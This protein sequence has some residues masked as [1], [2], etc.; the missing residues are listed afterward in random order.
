MPEGASVAQCSDLRDQAEL[1]AGGAVRRTTRH[2]AAGNDGAS[3]DFAAGSSAPSSTSSFEPQSTL[4]SEKER[5]LDPREDEG[6]DDSVSD[7]SYA[8]D[9]PVFGTHTGEQLAYY[10]Y[11]DGQDSTTAS[12]RPAASG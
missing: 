6:G 2:H 8:A 4:K 11:C 1:R 5:D 7:I 12:G 3:C 10:C 9:V